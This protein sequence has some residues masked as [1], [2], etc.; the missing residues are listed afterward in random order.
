MTKVLNFPSMNSK[1]KPVQFDVHQ[2]SNCL[3][4][5]IRQPVK[6]KSIPI[7]IKPWSLLYGFIQMIIINPNQPRLQIESING[8]L[9]INML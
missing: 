7:S 4:I 1:A 8:T 3:Q 9:H 5:K 2:Y 6:H